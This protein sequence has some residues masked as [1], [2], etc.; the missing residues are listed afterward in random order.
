MSAATPPP[1]HELVVVEDERALASVA[2]AR[3]AAAIE[4]AVASRGAAHVALSGGSTP[5]GAYR[6]LAARGPALAGAVWW[7]V[8]ERCVPPT[9]ERSNYGAA[10]AQLLEPAGIA[11]SRVRRMEGELGAEVA[12]RRYAACLTS[13]LG[14][15]GVP[16]LD[17]VIAGIGSDGH[18]ASLFPRTGSVRRGE[19]PVID[20][21]PG[22]GLEPRVTL[23]APVLLAARRVLVLASGAAKREPL[24]AAWTAGDEDETP[25][26]LYLR[27]PEVTWIVDAHALPARP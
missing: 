19:A 7:W 24:L 17:L 21:V 2:A 16:T 3:I 25:A 10:R 9:D 22:G 15:R 1:G 4:A 8:D 12:A 11:P 26:R 14:E 27:A 23:A 20:V 5:G 18:T 6:L 13:E